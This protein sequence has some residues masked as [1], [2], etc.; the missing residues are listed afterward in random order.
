MTSD[1]GY[2]MYYDK[3]VVTDPTSLEAIL[4]DCEVAGKN[5]Y[6]EINS[7]WYQ[8]A[9]FFATGAELT[10]ETDDNGDFTACN[11]SYASDAGLVAFKKMI[12]LKSSPAF[13][14]GSAIGE[15]TKVGAIVDG[16]W[17][18]NAAQDLFGENYACAKLPT[19]TGSDGETY[20]MS[21]FGGFK[22]LGVKPQEDEEKL[23]ACD[24]LA[25]FLSSEEV[26]LARFEEVGWGPSNLNAQAS[27]AV[28]A[29]IALSALTE[30]LAFSVPQG[31]YP[32]DYWTL[33]TS[34][35][36]SIISGEI[37]ADASDEDLMATLQKF[38]DT[39]ISYAE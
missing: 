4:A 20:Q 39:C 35:G 26:Q 6:M 3:S 11:A 24:A 32:G 25:A 19:F 22:L 33:A 10:Y 15:A 27:D 16:V 30:Q 34:L 13:Q 28:K 9:F 37:A 5:F 18:S 31:Q 7:G 12:E 1:N 36:D 23:M 21:G 29:N 2:F 17:D 14:N 38:Q 8:T